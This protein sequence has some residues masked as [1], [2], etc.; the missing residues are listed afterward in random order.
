MNQSTRDALE[1]FKKAIQNERV[2]SNKNENLFEE[3]RTN[4][5]VQSELDEI[6]KI[7]D[8][9]IYDYSQEGL[10]ISPGVNNAVFGYS[11][12]ELKKALKAENDADLSL[13]LFIMYSTFSFIYKESTTIQARDFI[14]HSDV[15]D[16]CEKKIKIIKERIENLESNNEEVD[17]SF[18]TLV[19]N[20]D[21]KSLVNPKSKAQNPM[22]DTTSSSKTAYINRVLRFFCDND[23]FC[24]EELQDVYLIQPR[25]SAI[26]GYYYD[27]V[28]NRNKITDFLNS[29]SLDY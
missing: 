22:N 23:L 28:D 25:L 7:F 15:L 6:C 27:E 17:L 16:A 2:S 3:Y 20:W 4:S 18:T 19:E 29:M 5:E 21:N 13:Y 11:N 8:L 14:K 10:F 24:R 9:N 1:I 12:A 26:A